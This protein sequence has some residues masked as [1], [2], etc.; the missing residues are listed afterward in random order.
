MGD[1]T[2][3][4]RMLK[5]VK[6]T[7]QICRD[8]G[9]SVQGLDDPEQDEVTVQGYA[10][11]YGTAFEVYDLGGF[12]FM[13]RQ[14]AGSFKRSLGQKPKVMLRL[15]HQTAFAST[16][17]SPPTLQLSEREDGLWYEGRVSKKNPEGLAMLIEMQR[18]TL[19]ESSVAYQI[20]DAEYEDSVEDG[21]EVLTQVVLS[22]DLHRGDVSVVQFGMNPDTTAALQALQLAGDADTARRVLDGLSARL[23]FS[24]DP[25]AVGQAETAET[26][27][28]EPQKPPQELWS[29]QAALDVLQLDASE[30]AV[31]AGC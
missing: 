6:V 11:R 31:R 1:R 28:P 5:P 12:R 27:V 9:Y 29:P 7:A 17:A 14:E 19:T 8:A 23:G 10:A 20:M 16:H 15:N 24:P 30:Q 21:V 26:G 18:G 22:G 13:R 25:C 3:L 2:V 4:D